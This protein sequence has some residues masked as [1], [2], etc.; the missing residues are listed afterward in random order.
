MTNGIVSLT[1][2]CDLRQPEA[3]D[4]VL[5]DAVDSAQNKSGVLLHTVFWRW[6]RGSLGIFRQ[7]CDQ[8]RC[9]TLAMTGNTIYLSVRE[10]LPGPNPGKLPGS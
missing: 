6:R 3:S 5:L 1:G 7:Q 2:L 8:K 10:L 4:A 9:D